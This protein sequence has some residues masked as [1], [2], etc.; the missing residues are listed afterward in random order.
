MND[1]RQKNKYL[2]YA[3][4]SS[5]S[6]ERQV[7]SIEDQILIMR[8]IA[9]DFGL[10][11]VDELTE[12]KS[13]KE[14]DTRPKFME[15]IERIE[16]GEADGILTWKIDRLSRNPI[17]SAK[18]QW[19]LQREVI[20]S[21]Q[22]VGRE[23]K[24][25]DNALILSVE[26]SMAN[27]YIRDLSKNVKRG[28][29]SKLDKG[30][31]PGT[32][33]LGYLNTKTEARGDNYIIKDPKRF[34]L[35]RKAWDLMLTGNYV[36]TYILDKINNE[37]GF[38]TRK[39]KRRGGKP[40]SRSTIYRIFTNPFY[41]GIIPYKELFIEGK[42]EAMV[43]L[44]EFDRVQVLLGRKGRP[45]PNR[46]E[47]AYTG[48]I[49]CGECG[50]F[51]SATYKEK[52]L[53]ST[54]ELKRYT[55]YYCVNARKHKGLCSQRHYTNVRKINKQIEEEIEKFTIIEDFKDWALEILHEENEKEIESRTKVYEM[56]QEAL[57]DSQKQLDN[58]TRLLI[59]ELIEEEGF[60]KEKT[61]LQNEIA[62]LKKKMKSTEDR[63]E[64]WI[65]LTEKTF[66][67][68]TYARKAFLEDDIAQ[69]REILSAL[70]LNCTLKDHNIAIDRHPWLIRIEESY[71]PLE[72]RY[73]EFELGKKPYTQRQKEAFASL[74]PL[75][76]GRRDLNPRSSP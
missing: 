60:K 72:S 40:M 64:K 4:K 44:E 11:V 22:T 14:P 59:K 71:P 52:V 17:D 16:N 51:V 53:K 47:Y 9:K 33:P 35:I 27:Q 1:D 36:P 7:Q 70:G 65:E 13:A 48:G 42:H 5:E 68:A 55:L 74:S 56:Q 25:E 3:R 10:K 67:F 6:D 18:V 29:K 58:L 28:L 8:G 66:H 23:Y 69:K 21:I 43:T 34:V 39:W 2:I 37:W 20:Q 41:A 62:Q 38:R 57:N 32:A 73:K 31:M 30:W 24:P 75:V 15:L 76:R 61:R 19:L 50:G 12:A 46:Y 63:A 45:R 49:V 54:G 26:S